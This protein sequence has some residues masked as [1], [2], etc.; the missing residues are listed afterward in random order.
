MPD[1]NTAR[2]R[3]EAATSAKQYF[4]ASRAAME[5]ILRPYGLGGTQ[6]WILQQLTRQDRIRQRDLAPMLHVER[7][8][9]SD[10]VLTLVRKGLVEQAADPAD[11]RQKVLR[12]THAGER[13]WS[14]LPDPMEILHSIAFGGLADADVATVADVL[15]GAAE[16][17]ER[18]RKEREVS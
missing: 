8:T 18:S 11:Q 14:T 13:L 17:L 1:K 6:W 3:D 12:L 16:R 4:L 2:L 5:G 15:R 7:A 10:I 9:A